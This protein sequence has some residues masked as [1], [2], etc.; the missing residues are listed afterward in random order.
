MGVI[1]LILC[2]EVAECVHGSLS[3][4]FSECES[5]YVKGSSAGKNC[6]SSDMALVVTKDDSSWAKDVSDSYP[7]SGVG[8]V[9]SGV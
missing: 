4:S 6:V 7:C 5:E 8:Y 1:V 9:D 3:S 2:I